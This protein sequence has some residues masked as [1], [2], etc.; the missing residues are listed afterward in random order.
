VN[1]VIVHSLALSLFLAAAGCESVS[2][3]VS[4]VSDFFENNLSAKKKQQGL[5]RVDDLLARV[6]Q[7]HV[8]V[9]LSKE[10]VRGAMEALRTLV[11]PEFGGDAVEAY[12]GFVSA[13][14]ASEKQ[15]EKLAE[16]FDPMEK[17]ADEVFTAWAK[18]LE[19]FSN[20]EMRDHSQ[21]RL[22]ETR[23]RYEA[24]VSSAEPAMWAYEALNRSLRDHALFLGHDFNAAA[25]SA[26]EGEVDGLLKH[27]AQLDKRFEA[28]LKAAKRYVRSTALRGQVQDQ[29][30]EGEEADEPAE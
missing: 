7:L 20:A 13:I 2:S 3:G 28:V 18:S 8:E 24:I 10:S 27:A 22:E 6:E 26:L 16:A 12:K 25:I 4:G 17:T 9:E 11:G 15:A 14:E 5:V 1:R 29:A 21:V 19:S 30:P 23:E